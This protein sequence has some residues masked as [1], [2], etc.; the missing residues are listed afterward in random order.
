MHVRNN[1]WNV[2]EKTYDIGY[3]AADHVS[4]FSRVE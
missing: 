1:D 3:Y 2:P 4:V